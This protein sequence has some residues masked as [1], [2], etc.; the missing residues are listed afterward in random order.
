MADAP[1]I[2]SDESCS[3]ISKEAHN[4]M[5][6]LLHMGQS[7]NHIFW[8]VGTGNVAS[9][10]EFCTLM[11]Y[12]VVFTEFRSKLWREWF[13]EFYKD[14]DPKMPLTHQF[15]TK[16]QECSLSQLTG[17]TFINQ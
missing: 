2:N 8:G 12:I 1:K 14:S 4:L 17:K 5:V 9:K 13:P 6:P 3:L 15:S 11:D 16:R 7:I 10:E